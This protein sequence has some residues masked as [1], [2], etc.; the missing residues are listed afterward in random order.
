MSGPQT[1][2]RSQL[3][4]AVL[5]G[6]M[7]FSLLSV[8]PAQATGEPA[9]L[10]AQDITAAFDPLTEVTTITWENSDTNDGNAI[11]GFAGAEYNVYRHNAP[12]DSSNVGGLTPFATVDA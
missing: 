5:V 8:A 4:A 10:H 2:R 1:E 12:I 7:L 9:N 11:Q 3:R 6:L